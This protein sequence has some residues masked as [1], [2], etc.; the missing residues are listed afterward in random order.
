MR[1]I[2]IF[3]ACSSLIFR[4][5]S[6]SGEDGASC[7]AEL[8]DA[9]ELL[10]TQQTLELAG[11]QGKD[12]KSGQPSPASPAQSEHASRVS[13]DGKVSAAKIS[14]QSSPRNLAIKASFGQTSSAFGA[15][16]FSFL[17]KRKH[18]RRVRKIR[19]T[20]KLAH[21]QEPGEEGTAEEE[22]EEIELDEQSIA[23]F[24][25]IPI[26]F[27][28][29][30][31]MVVGATLEKKHIAWLPES[32]VTVGLGSILGLYMKHY[33]GNFE[34]F[35]NQEVFNDTCGTLLQL[36]LLPT[37]MFEAGWSLR[38]RDFCAQFQYI[39]TFAILGSL[40]SFVTVALL[41]MLTGHLGFH[42]I[43]TAR[44]AFAYASLVAATDPV[45]TLATFSHKKVA[46]LLN[47]LTFGDSVFNDAVAIILFR[48][49]N[50]N[51]IMGN[52][53]EP[54]PP[55]PEISVKIVGGIFEIFFGSLAIGLGLAL[56]F[57]AVLRTV[58]LSEFPR[59]IT[60]A[61]TALAFL[62]FACGEFFNMSGII[63]TIF[64]S[65]FLGIYARP[66]LS[67]EGSIL[68]NFFLRQV[69]NMMDHLVFLLVG[70]CLAGM[71]TTNASGWIFG[72]WVML[73]CLCG[74]A[75]CVFPSSAIINYVKRKIG[76]AYDT[77]EENR[78]YL[79]P[80]IIYMMWHAGL[81]GAI[82]MTLCMEIGE[83]ADELDGEGTRH[84]MQT[85]TYF[86]IAVFLF[87]F[88][89]TTE[90]VLNYW[91]I[92]MGDTSPF[93]RLYREEVPKPMQRQLSFMDMTYLEPIFVGQ[94]E[95]HDRM[96]KRNADLE[97]ED[98]LKGSD[99]LQSH[100][101]S[102]LHRGTSSLLLGS[103]RE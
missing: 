9:M 88:G 69:A 5:H 92:P 23:Q 26:A 59:V 85:G 42:S 21:R 78:H 18:N 33:L 14:T 35:D 99:A 43:T 82:A 101:S 79:S 8:E 86:M 6:G 64:G 46:A 71:G 67:E 68:S 38:K 34:L 17:G 48:V 95:A 11:T 22:V 29:I 28:V 10:Q 37:L 1:S 76:D 32:A 75:A 91:K 62:I 72:L 51:G 13:S 96:Q 45:A 89:G 77:P 20:V 19:K 100:V 93:D 84:I 15:L 87:V 54:S 90:M 40:L 44:C 25:V 41:M 70:F 63:A 47:I 83:W 81:R 98:A 36:F 2:R 66:H 24:L 56:L 94:G 61:L 39:C 57:L 52:P 58:D 97:V 102:K 16:Q 103:T 55:L 60:L 4:V 27:A 31:S 80:G 65:I 73:F 53:G 49:L 7:K 3:L 12:S 30:V 74:R 50:N